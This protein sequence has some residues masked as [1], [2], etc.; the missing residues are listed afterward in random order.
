MAGDDK[1]KPDKKGKKRKIEPVS[2]NKFDRDGFKKNAAGDKLIREYMGEIAFIFADVFEQALV[3][4]GY[5]F[6]FDLMFFY[7]LR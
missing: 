2:D 3:I 5:V 7:M 6:L 4:N 1:R